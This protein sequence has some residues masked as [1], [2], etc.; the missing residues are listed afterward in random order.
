MRL[1]R[2]DLGRM[3]AMTALAMSYLFLLAVAWK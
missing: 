2:P 1:V 3:L